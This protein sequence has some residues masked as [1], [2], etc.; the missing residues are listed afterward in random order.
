MKSN[1]PNPITGSNVQAADCYI[2]NLKDGTTLYLTNCDR[3]ITPPAPSSN[4]QISGKY[5]GFNATF[6]PM[7]ITRG[8]MSWKLGVAPSDVGFTIGVGPT[9]IADVGLD[10]REAAARGLFDWAELVI[11]RTYGNPLFTLNSDGTASSSF[12]LPLFIGLIA[13][14]NSDRGRVVFKAYDYRVTANMMLPRYTYGA[15]CRWTLYNPGDGAHGCPVDRNAFAFPTTVAAGSTRGVIQ[16]PPPAATL[17]PGPAGPGWFNQGYVLG[18]GGNNPNQRASIRSYVPAVQSW[19]QTVLQDGPLAFYPCADPPGSPILRDISGNN[20]NGS[21]SG[22]SFGQTDLGPGNGLAPGMP[23]P[24]TT[25]ARFLGNSYATLPVPPPAQQPGFGGGYTFEFVMGLQNIAFFPA[26]FDTAPSQNHALR[27]WG[28]PGTA[29]GTGGAEGDLVAE[30][31]NTTF[32]V[33]QVAGIGVHV[34]VI[35]RSVRT[36]EIYINGNLAASVTTGGSSNVAWGTSTSYG[37]S[38]GPMTLGR[39]EP[40]GNDAV[41]LSGSY[42]YYTGWLQGF[43]IYAFPFSPGQ[44]RAHAIAALT[45][46]ST[47]ATATLYLVE[48]LPVQPTTGDSIILY[49]GCDLTYP[50]CVRKFNVGQWF[51]GF[52][53]I[54]D[55]EQAI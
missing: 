13:E 16:I 54:P 33:G 50:T 48:K 10:Y 9:D 2:L 35:F 27:V 51:G 43:G 28:G 25:A 45:A 3:K 18:V 20:Y 31:T 19:I 11:W 24:Y 4:A 32:A 30:W 34:L 15:Q 44:A 14:A 7:R 29:Q 37:G 47:S 26:I 1:A 6:V 38:D 5:A 22:I 46:Y 12:T 49:P 41:N 23:P 36:A 17:I 55:P 42:Q 39:V 21:V 40:Y 8:Q 52:P 53:T